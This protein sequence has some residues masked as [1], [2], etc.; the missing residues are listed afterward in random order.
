MNISTNNKKIFLSYGIVFLINVMLNVK[1]P[2]FADDNTFMKALDQFG[3]LPNWVVFYY[4]NWSGRIIPHT[5]LVLFLNIPKIFFDILN[6]GI[7]TLLV[8]MMVKMCFISF[9]K[10]SNKKWIAI[11]FIQLFVLMFMDKNVFKDAALWKSAAVLYVWGLCAGI[12]AILPF[13]NLLVDN[14]IEKKDF[15]ISMLCG[16]YASNVEQIAAFVVAS[17]AILLLVNALKNKCVNM[18]E[19]IIFVVVTAGMI[20]SLLAPGNQL[21]KTE[22]ILCV[23]PYYDMY[24]L[25]EKIV[26][27]FTMTMERINNY[28]A[29]YYLII[30]LLLCIIIFIKK[31]EGALVKGISLIPFLYYTFSFIVYKSCIKELFQQNTIL[32]KIKQYMFSYITVNG[33]DFIM[34]IENWISMILGMFCFWLMVMLIFHYVNDRYEWL[35]MLLFGGAFGT[36][37]MLIFSPAGQATGPRVLFPMQMLLIAS[38]LRLFLYLLKGIDS[39]GEQRL[40]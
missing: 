8:A 11:I 30:S 23:V 4:N 5:L 24:S 18:Y 35:A 1:M 33:T 14:Q 7:F 3:G 34:K 38:I 13:V 31:D 12:M 28:C 39:C 9:E 21:R 17:M 36:V 6:A 15:I 16:L 37:Y 22:D 25:L 40:L 19:I 32:I 2:I 20:I 29:I 10:Y 27:G 26:W